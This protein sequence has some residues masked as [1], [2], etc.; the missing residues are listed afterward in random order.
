MAQSLKW[1]MQNGQNFIAEQDGYKISV[2][3]IY[4][5]IHNQNNKVVDCCY[6]HPNIA[7]GELQAKVQAERAFALIIN[8]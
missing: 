2:N 7:T 1:K 4:W 5:Y 3:H 6:Y 8:L